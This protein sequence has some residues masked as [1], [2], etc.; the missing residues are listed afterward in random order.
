VILAA[1][2]SALI[3]MSWMEGPADLLAVL[4][5]SGSGEDLLV[6]STL[7]IPLYFA[8]RL[9][10]ERGLISARWATALR[11]SFV[12]VLISIV[13][14]WAG[15]SD[16]VRVLRYLQLSLGAHLLAAFVPFARPGEFNG[17]WQYNRT[18]FLRVLLTGIYAHVLYAGLA[19]AILAIDRLFGVD[20]YD[21][22]YLDLLF[23]IGFVFST[24]FFISGVPGKLEQLESSED[25]PRGFKLF[26]QFVLIPLVTIYLT[27]LTAYFGKVLLT[28]EWPS[29]WI[30]WL[31]SSVSVVGILSILLTYP[32]RDR[33]ENRWIGSYVRWFWIVMIPAILMLLVASWK[34]I[35]QY[36]ITEPRYFLVVLTLWL[37]AMAVLYGIRRS[38]NI[39]LIPLSLCILALLTVAGPWGNG[40]MED[41]RARPTSAEVSLEDRRELSG[42]LT[43]LLAGHGTGHMTNLLGPELAMTDSAGG[44]GALRDSDA[45]ERASAILDALGVDYVAGRRAETSFFTYRADSSERMAVDGYTYVFKTRSNDASIAWGAGDSMQVVLV[46]DE[47]RLELKD[48]NGV[49]LVDLPLGEMLARARAADET[50]GVNPSLPRDVLRVEA[51]GSGLRVTLLIDSVHGERTDDGVRVNGIFANWLVAVLVEG[52]PADLSAV[53]PE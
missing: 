15:W 34:R 10:Q 14:Q 41:G 23:T 31:V 13:W 52:I 35:A 12:A 24:W 30:G 43:Y 50:R 9:A 46:Q 18:L 4:T 48:A 7:A 16:Q 6:A 29:G 25:Y 51:A 42:S 44:Q 3:P 38:Q 53:R 8:L 47:A 49:V 36:G 2:L 11:V 20:W 28:A 22:V 45:G 1:V 26:A 19:I 33:E 37:A 39:K 27:I 32:I 21:E 17:F 5:R 40:M